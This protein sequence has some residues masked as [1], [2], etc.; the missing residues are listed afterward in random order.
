MCTDAEKQ[1]LALNYVGPTHIFCAP[2]LNGVLASKIG[3][4]ELQK[5]LASPDRYRQTIDKKKGEKFSLLLLA[6][7][8]SV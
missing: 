2:L 7:P 1:T 6:L 8:L 5:G 4:Q 3:M